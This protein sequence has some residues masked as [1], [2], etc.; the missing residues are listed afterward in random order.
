MRGSCIVGRL[1]RASAGEARVVPARGDT[2]TL[3]MKLGEMLVRD[4]HLTP[5][6]LEQALAR[7]GKDGGRLGT[8][9]VEMGAVD[10]DMLT[11]YLGLELSL[12]IATGPTLER[13]KRTAVRLLTPEQAARFRCVPLLISERQLIGAIDDPHDLVMLDELART[14]GYRVIPRVAPEI[15]I[16]YYLERYYGVR[17]PERFRRFGDTPR[18]YARNDKKA[19]T[20]LPGPSLPGLPPAKP[21]VPAPNPAPALRTRTPPEGARLASTPPPPPPPAEEREMDALEVDAEDLVIELE[22]D[23]AETADEAPP[24]AAAFEAAA[25]A[26][27]PARSEPSAPLSVKEATEIMRRARQRGEVADAVMGHA[28]GVFDVAALLIARDSFAFGWKGFGIDLTRDRLEVL[29]IPLDAPSMFQMAV[30]A[31]QSVFAG[32]V[33]PAALHRYLYKALRTSPP[34]QAVVCAISIGK[35]VVNLLYGHKAGNTQLSLSELDGV[36]RIAEE[37]ALSYVRLIAVSKRAST[38]DAEPEPDDERPTGPSRRARATDGGGAP[39]HGRRSRRQEP[40][41][42]MPMATRAADGE[43]P[44]GDGDAPPKRR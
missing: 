35:R 22:A 11:V 37:A 31:E 44:D 18:G 3:A 32:A 5:E 13:A 7:Q 26:A 10:L 17:R 27:E 23:A 38:A 2:L 20:R 40:R 39:G 19:G 8:V 25:P 36:R 15:R 34:K 6:Q 41:E 42:T 21:P 12:P 30:K 28:R 4:G 33:F 16:F 9:L 1:A 24:T 29:L 43:V 14:T